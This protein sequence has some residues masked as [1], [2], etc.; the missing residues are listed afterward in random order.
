MALITIDLKE[1]KGFGIADLVVLMLLVALVAGLAVLGQQWGSPYQATVQIDLSPKALLGYSFLSLS[2]G[3]GAYIISLA[4]TFWWALWAARSKAVERVI[5]P[6]VDILQSVPVLGFMPGL[7]LG[8]VKLFP[9]SRMGLELAGILLIFTSQA[10]N[11]ILAFYQS[12]TSIP[13]DL[14]ASAELAGLS[15]VKR[16]FSMELPCGMNVL[17]WNSMM[18]MAGGWF[19]LTASE[20][21][22]LGNQDFRLPGVGS[23]MSVA[24]EQGNVAAMVYAVIAMTLMVVAVDQLLWRPLLAWSFRFR[25][26]EQEGLRPPSSWMLDLL[27]RSKALRSLGERIAAKVISLILTSVPGVVMKPI[28]R[29]VSRTARLEYLETLV[30]AAFGVASF[31]G[32]WR[33]LSLLSEISMRQW[34]SLWAEAGFTLLRT[35]FATLLG[36]LWAIPLGVKIGT[37]PRLA[38]IFG[39]VIQMTA[40]FPAPMLF[41]AV[42]VVLFSLGLNLEV[43]SVFLMMTGTAWYILFNVIAGASQIPAEQSEAWQLYGGLSRWQRWKRFILPSI[44]PSLLVGW[45]TAMGG[46]WNASIL[47][48][49]FRLNDVTHTAH[50]LGATINLATEKGDFALLTAAV[51]VMVLIVVAINRLFWHRMYDIAYRMAHG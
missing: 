39:P 28:R 32:S 33:L 22:Q 6:L 26:E 24:M 49:Y 16:F 3:F 41:P 45:E 47:T 5:I 11:M 48:E 40:S 34:G 14:K 13:D 51:L 7:V 29:T 8:L 10:W 20:A 37:N 31:W 38:K 19:F 4:V 36:S 35:V 18:S 46:A 9:D 21:F 42:L 44:F 23:Y 15:P 17:A 1:L 27:Q 50:G 12:L 43:A 30:V 2:R 25:L